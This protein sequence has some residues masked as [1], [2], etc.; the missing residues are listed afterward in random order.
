MLRNK[1]YTSC[2][3]WINESLYGCGFTF[4]LEPYYSKESVMTL[5]TDEVQEQILLYKENIITGDLVSEENNLS[6]C[7]L[8]LFTI[9]ACK[10][11]KDDTGR[12]LEILTKEK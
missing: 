9:E 7:W 12:P 5:H 4:Y 3:D 1:F 10:D 6:H 11:K 2:F 8:N